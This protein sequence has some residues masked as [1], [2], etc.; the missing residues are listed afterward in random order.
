MIRGSVLLLPALL[1]AWAVALCGELPVVEDPRVWTDQSVD[2]STIERSLKS[3]IKAGMSD[4]QKVLACYHWIRR[5]LYHGDGPIQYAYNFHNLIHIFGNGSCLRQTTPLW[6]LLDKL[7]FKCRTGAVGGHHIIE[8]QYGGKWHLFDPHTNFFV[9]DRE[10]PAAIASI[11]ASRVV[12]WPRCTPRPTR[13]PG[14][15]SR[16]GPAAAPTSSCAITAP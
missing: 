3:L 15:A 7:G 9:Y 2:C 14:G 16:T 4:E 5:V 1:L 12:A 11:A 8:V 10:K 6:V 13:R